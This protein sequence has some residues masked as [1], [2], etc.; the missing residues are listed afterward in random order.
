ML[1]DGGMLRSRR[2]GK[3][4]YYRADP[5]TASA[6]LDDLQAFLRSCC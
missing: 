3:T 1:R 5:E 6:V 4:V 2:N